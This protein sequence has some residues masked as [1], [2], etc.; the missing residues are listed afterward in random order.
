MTGP[1]TIL[2]NGSYQDT[3][4]LMTELRDCSIGIEI[5]FEESPKDTLDAIYPVVRAAVIGEI[6][7]NLRS[8]GSDG[9]VVAAELR[10]GKFR[11][12]KPIRLRMGWRGQRTGCFQRSDRN[13]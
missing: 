11:R 12:P 5:G 1:M 3:L 4:P 7:D 10:L 9:L 13:P 6:T 2:V 8:D